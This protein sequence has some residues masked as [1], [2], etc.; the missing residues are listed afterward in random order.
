MVLSTHFDPSAACS[1]W[2]RLA[3]C[4]LYQWVVLYL[5]ARPA[6]SK[7][8]MRVMRRNNHDHNGVKHHDRDDDGTRTNFCHRA[9]AAAT[10]AP[11]AEA[12]HS[13]RGVRLALLRVLV[14]LATPEGTK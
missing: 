2:V 3:L 10:T 11:S 9:S 14:G 5:P 6:A 13:I 8:R 12:H 7:S 4:C 1:M